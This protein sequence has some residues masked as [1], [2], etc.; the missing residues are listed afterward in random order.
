MEIDYKEIINKIKPEMEKSIAFLEKEL[1]KIRTSRASPVLIENIEI[2]CF[3]KTFPLKQLGSILTTG[4]RQLTFYPWDQSY[5]EPVEKALR[6]AGIS[7]TPIIE[8]KTI[9][10]NFPPLSEE[11]REDLTKKVHNLAEAIKQTIRRWREKAWDEIQDK[12]RE[13][14][15]REDDKY[16]AKDQLQDLIEEYYEKIEKIIERK[17]KEIR[18]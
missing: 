11:Y 3:G 8:G 4:P 14:K 1:S 17:E 15:I 2:N 18:E 10:I 6:E 12:T 16:R 7:G 13:G 9:K 5:L